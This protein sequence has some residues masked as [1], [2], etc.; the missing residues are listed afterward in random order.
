MPAVN[1]ALAA[2]R[3][4]PASWWILGLSGATAANL[5]SNL[6]L[7][8]HLIM[9]S[10]AIILL[11]RDDSARGKSLRFYFV[12]C[13]VIVVVRV[14]LHLI[15]QAEPIDQ[16]SVWLAASDALKLAAIIVC[17]AV[18]N[19]LANPRELLRSTPKALYELGAAIV[20]AINL[21]PQLVTSLQRVRRAAAL[22]G[23]S[24]GMRSLNGILIPTLEDALQRSLDLAASMSSRG[25]GARQPQPQWRSRVAIASAFVSLSLMALATYSLLATSEETVGIAL[26]AGSLLPLAV[27][28]RLRGAGVV[29]TRFRMRKLVWQDLAII[30][31]ALCVIWVGWYFS[32]P[33]VGD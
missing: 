18:A 31:I 20:I 3:V 33:V 4:H 22:R 17:I 24:K 5:A 7:S 23:R 10:I 25:F 6:W 12:V 27:F 29:R 9:W 28:V 2:S 26:A 11:C 8:S 32:L 15:F 30:G 21:A 14:G 13:S 19:S 16:M 1:H